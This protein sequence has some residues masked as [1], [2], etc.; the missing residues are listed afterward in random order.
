[1]TKLKIKDTSINMDKIINEGA[2]PTD[3]EAFGNI[4]TQEVCKKST[5]LNGKKSAQTK[6][7]Q[8]K[9]PWPQT[10]TRL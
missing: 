4:I 7:Q 10:R 5:K 6:K 2:K 3:N 8:Q 1:M 9:T